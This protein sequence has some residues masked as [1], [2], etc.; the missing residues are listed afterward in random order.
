[1]TYSYWRSGPLNANTVLGFYFQWVQGNRLSYFNKIFLLTVKHLWLNSV[2]KEQQKKYIFQICFYHSMCKTK[3][4]V[5]IYICI[6]RLKKNMWHTTYIRHIPYTYIFVCTL[7]TYMVYTWAWIFVCRHLWHRCLER[8]LREV[9]KQRR[10][11]AM[12]SLGTRIN[13]SQWPC[14]KPSLWWVTCKLGRKCSFL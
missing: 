1:M 12:A 3:M 5:C 2:K 9:F 4:Y 14:G 7:H 10:L 8:G 13:V 11:P 6:E